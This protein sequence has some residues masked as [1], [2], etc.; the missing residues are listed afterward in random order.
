M[1]FSL[2]AAHVVNEIIAVRINNMRS[3][4]RRIKL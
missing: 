4:A 2:T 1:C 3:F